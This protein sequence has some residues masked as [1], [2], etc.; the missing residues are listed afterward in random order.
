MNRLTD[1]VCVIT[2][3]GSG[4]GRASAEM[5]AREGAIVVV[6][7]L[8]ANTA[9]DVAH[10]I[11]SAG[12]RA[13]ALRVDV[14][15]EDDL[16]TMIGTPIAQ[17]GRIDVLFN[18]ALFMKH[19]FIMRDMDFLAFDPEVFYANMRVNVLGGV[20][21]SKFAIPHMLPN[22]GGSIIFT[23][24]TSSIG[25]DVTAFSYGASK[26][27][28]NWYVQSIA[29][30]FGKR[31]IR[32]NGILPGVIQTPAMRG[33]TTPEMEAGFHEIMNTPRLGEP[34]DVAAMAVYLASDESRYINGVLYRVDGGMSCTVPFIGVSR[35]AT[36]MAE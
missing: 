9:E 27:A 23:S 28:L 30:T 35:K 22:G 2:G 8:R 3:A 26:A 29:A 24:S 1:K 19:D 7:D 36:G 4:I 15:E 18:N 17:Y 34:D 12:G 11:T 32:S 20:L 31:G 21:A 10:A 5:F 33:W 14:G 25:G 6:T 13:I 16:R